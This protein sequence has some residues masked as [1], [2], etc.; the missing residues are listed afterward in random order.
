MDLLFVMVHWHRLAKLRMHNDITLDIMEKLTII[1]GEKL[2]TFSQDTCPAFDTKE[3]H[4]EYNTRIRRESE[5]LT[6]S[7]KNPDAPTQD[8]SNALPASSTDE[9]THAK[10]N[11]RSVKARPSGRRK[12]I[13]NLQTYKVHLL[14]DYVKT[15]RIYGTSD[16]YLSEP[17]C[18]N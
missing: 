17:V 5:K 1:L 9:R 11:P 3:L 7:N 8:P 15:I 4:R 18:Y 12:V 14:G 10:S 6:N 13:F 16:S 2:R